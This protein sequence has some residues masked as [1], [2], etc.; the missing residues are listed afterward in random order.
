MAIRST[1]TIWR[2]R[3]PTSCSSIYFATIRATSRSIRRSRPI[4]AHTSRRCWQCG[5]RTIRSSCPRAPKRSSVTSQRGRPIL[6]HW[7][8]R[9]GD[10]CRRDRVGDPR[11][12][13]GIGGGSHAPART[14]RR[15]H[16]WERA[17]G[18]PLVREQARSGCE[19]G[20]LPTEMDWRHLPNNLHAE[21]EAGLDRE[22]RASTTAEGLGFFFVNTRLLRQPRRGR[23]I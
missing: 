2:G 6:R 4:S 3:A 17:G 5:A 14:L 13:C 22:D 9:F 16:P 23:G 1:I 11:F 21:Q 19:T 20:L 7:A 12:S 8:F 15:S 10:A 18:K